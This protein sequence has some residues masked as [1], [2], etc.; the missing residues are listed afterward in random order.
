VLFSLEGGYNLEALG[1]NVVS[2]LRLCLEYW[3]NR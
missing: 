2:T 3:Y 1:R